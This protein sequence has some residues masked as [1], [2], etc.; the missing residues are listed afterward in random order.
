MSCVGQ[1]LCLQV[2]VGEMKVCHFV[3]STQIK[4]VFEERKGTG[5]GFTV[6]SFWSS[7]LTVST[8]LISLFLIKN[9][10]HFSCSSVVFSFMYIS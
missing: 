2:I 5:L 4:V 6:E 8:L 7:Y 1:K 3:H 10:Q 9:R